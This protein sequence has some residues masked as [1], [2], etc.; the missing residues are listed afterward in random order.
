MSDPTVKG[1]VPQ[2]HSHATCNPMSMLSL[3]LLTYWLYIS[4]IHT[5]SPLF[6]HLL[7]Y[8]TELR[9]AIYLVD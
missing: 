5:T 8:L 9:K 2:Y 4:E 1:S 6:D 3:M 7:G